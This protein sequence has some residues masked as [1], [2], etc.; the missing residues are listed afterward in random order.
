MLVKFKISKIIHLSRE[1]N[2]RSD[3]LSKLANPMALMINH[4]FVQETS[5]NLNIET[6][7]VAM[8]KINN[9]TRTSWMLLANSAESALVK[10]IC[11][12]YSLIQAT[13]YR[14]GLLTPLL[15]C[16]EDW[17]DNT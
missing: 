11:N 2:T 9:N 8:M 6:L 4:S 3:I 10:T 16:M 14:R 5:K 1:H 15:K 7:E 12:S 17:L 13:L